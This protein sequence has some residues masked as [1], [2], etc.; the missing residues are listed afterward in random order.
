ML[1]NEFLK[2]KYPIIQG[3]MARIATG[4]FAA[5]VANAGALGIIASGGLTAEE[6][7]EQIH[8]ARKITDKPFGV[9][10]MLMA[11]DVQELADMLVEE[12]PA[13]IT[14]GAGNPAKYVKAWKDAGIKVI[15]VVASASLAK[16]MER[17]GADAVVAE[18]TESG[19][20]IGELTTMA[21]V[22][23]VVDAVNIPVIAAGGVASGRQLAAVIA[24]GAIGAQVGTIVLASDEAPIHE[25][26]K[27]MLLSAK[28]TGT[29][30]TGRSKG[31]PVRVLKTKKA[32]ESARI[33]NEST[34]MAE[35][36]ALRFGSLTLA[37]R[38][39]D[40]DN[41]SFMAGQVAG[42][43]NEVR[44]LADIFAGLI[45]EYRETVAGMPEL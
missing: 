40:K 1:L 19:G 4:E 37:V 15:P 21:L 41:G 32:R 12:K 30:V 28:D 2:I 6:T 11:P 34:D 45:D 18:G 22:P 44:P 16:L 29:I 23:Q 26:Y 10:V 39:G 20:H 24:M 17:C 7:R 36:E 9:N 5:A 33:E 27:Q 31:A 3:A 8:I 42:M 13:V 35:L 14:T 25:N 43:L 38:D